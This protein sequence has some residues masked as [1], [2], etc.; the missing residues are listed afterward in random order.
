MI[1]TLEAEIETWRPDKT[2][3]V[4][5]AASAMTR[6]IEAIIATTSIIV[7]AFVAT[8]ALI[9]LFVAMAITTLI[10]L[11][12]VPLEAVIIVMEVLTTIMIAA[13]EVFL[14]FEVL[15]LAP[16]APVNLVQVGRL[17]HRDNG[18]GDVQRASKSWRS[19]NQTSCQ[20]AYRSHERSSQF[21]HV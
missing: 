5:V 13:T 9:P 14:R 20:E 1:V 3:T 4:I 6:T 10:F 17:I 15:L 18:L 7:V 16:A 8:S 2:G 12:F 11:L 19:A 21:G